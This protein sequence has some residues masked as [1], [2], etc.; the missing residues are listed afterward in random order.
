[1]ESTVDCGHSHNSD[2]VMISR[3]D[4]T[5]SYTEIT[6]E[7]AETCK[8]DQENSCPNPDDEFEAGEATLSR[9]LSPS[10]GP[11]TCLHLQNHLA[12][13]RHLGD[14]LWQIDLVVALRTYDHYD[15]LLKLRVDHTWQ[16]L[17]IL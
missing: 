14:T 16:S 13:H 11:L 7:T 6:D 15:F 12:R 2:E 9:V 10:S 1:M 3:L 8:C 17:T 5:L 4:S